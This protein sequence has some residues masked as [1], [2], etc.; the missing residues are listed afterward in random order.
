VEEKQTAVSNDQ[1]D[2]SNCLRIL[3]H[4]LRLIAFFSM[5]KPG[6]HIVR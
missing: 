6:N 5:E 1:D 4:P 3:F 2:G